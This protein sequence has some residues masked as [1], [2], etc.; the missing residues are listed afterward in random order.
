MKQ[1]EELLEVIK[2]NLPEQSVSVIKDLIAKAD[3]T[4]ELVTTVNNNISKI[5]ELTVS[6]DK[7]TKENNELSKK[8]ISLKERDKTVS[9]NEEKQ[10]ITIAELKQASA[11]EKVELM[12]DLVYRVFGNK[13]IMETVNKNVSTG[14][15]YIGNGGTQHYTIG[16]SEVKTQT[17]GTD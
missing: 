17:I 11:E 9:A 5:A 10:K 16:E 8:N 4:D 6:V 12:K 14:C 13:V 7:L 3:K 1:E 15:D 2:K